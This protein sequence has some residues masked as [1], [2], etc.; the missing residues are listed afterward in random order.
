VTKI[1]E[2]LWN[3]IS[4]NVETFTTGESESQKEL[5]KVRNVLKV[6]QLSAEPMPI[7]ASQTG[8]MSFAK[9]EWV[10]QGAKYVEEPWVSAVNLYV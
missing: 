1:I 5:S 7:Q 10:G 3:Q 6:P 9:L 8:K 4:K 2:G